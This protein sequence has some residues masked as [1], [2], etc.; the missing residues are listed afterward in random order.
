M[1]KF[2]RPE[3]IPLAFFTHASKRPFTCGIVKSKHVI[4]CGEHVKGAQT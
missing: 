4:I 2:T 1:N 3:E